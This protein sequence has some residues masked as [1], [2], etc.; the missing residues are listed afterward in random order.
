ML[1]G[2]KLATV[3]LA[4]MAAPGF[5]VE[6]LYLDEVPITYPGDYLAPADLYSVVPPPAVPAYTVGSLVPATVYDY[7][8]ADTHSTS[9]Y[10][11]YGDYALYSKAAAPDASDEKLRVLIKAGLD[12]ASDVP[13]A[14]I[15]DYFANV[16]AVDLVAEGDDYDVLVEI[17]TMK[18]PSTG[19]VFVVINAS[20]EVD[21]ES[22]I[23]YNTFGYLGEQKVLSGS[24]DYAAGLEDALDAEAIRQAE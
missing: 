18:L 23:F 7:G 11:S 21:G 14:V 10:T 6:S 12:N 5:S 1:G 8:L 19:T 20:K 17:E 15:K 16:D 3:V 13:L 9:G 4:M 2:K 24:A 22:L